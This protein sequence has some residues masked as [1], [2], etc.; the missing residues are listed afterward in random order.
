MLRSSANRVPRVATGKAPLLEMDPTRPSSPGGS[1]PA[2]RRLRR[3]RRLHLVRLRR[4]DGDDGAAVR[5]FREPRCARPRRP[6]CRSTSPAT[7]ADFVR[8]A[9]PA[10]IFA[11][12]RGANRHVAPS[13]VSDRALGHR[14]RSPALRRRLQWN[15]HRARRSRRSGRRDRRDRRHL[16]GCV[17]RRDAGR[18]GQ[19]HRRRRRR[20]RRRS[21]WRGG[22][23][24][25]SPR[26]R[27]EDVH[28][29]RRSVLP[30]SEL[31]NVL[32]GGHDAAVWERRRRLPPGGRLCPRPPLLPSKPRR[33]RLRLG[34]RADVPDLA[35]VCVELR[36]HGGLLRG[37]IV[38]R[39]DR[40]ACEG[41]P[42][43]PLLPMT[44][45]GMR[46]RDG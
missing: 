29:A 40:H 3:P 24:A 41:L 43:E 35:A 4:S 1:F 21:R 5:F 7:T 42:D 6:R 27:N 9:C 26:V 25:G 39:R 17:G 20:R 45:A 11:F 13:M 15:E 30:V 10:C 2:R 18:E 31:R 22:R 12:A 37:P 34:L 14:R 28:D 44:R 32:P 19:R 16:G 38:P 46:R 36:M 23:D 33:L 8:Y